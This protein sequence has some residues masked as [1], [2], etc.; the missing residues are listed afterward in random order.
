MVNKLF[1]LFVFCF[2][3]AHKSE[4]SNLGETQ[5]GPFKLYL[6]HKDREKGIKKLSHELFVLL[7]SD[8]YAFGILHIQNYVSRI[9]KLIVFENILHTREGGEMS[10]NY[11]QNLNNRLYFL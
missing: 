5:L 3:K 8:F 9:K 7:N 10:P 1:H 11:N 2:K 6:T 4:C